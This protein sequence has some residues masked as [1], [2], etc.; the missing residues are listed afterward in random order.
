MRILKNPNQKPQ[1]L[2]G[3]HWEYYYKAFEM[4]LITGSLIILICMQLYKVQ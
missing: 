3:G 1:L 4:P 2:K